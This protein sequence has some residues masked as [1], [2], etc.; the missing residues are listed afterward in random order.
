LEQAIDAAKQSGA[1]GS[2]ADALANLGDVLVERG[3]LALAEQKYTESIALQP[4]KSNKSDTLVALGNL[5]VIEG[6]LDAA[7][8]RFGQSQSAASKTGLASILLAKGSA[9][10]A[11][12]AIRASLTELSKEDPEAGGQARL[13]LVQALLEQ[14]KSVDALKEIVALNALVKAT[15][16]RSL[17]YGALIASARVQA[18]T[19]PQ[20]KVAQPVESLQKVALDA[21][22][23]GMPGF[24]LQARLAIAEIELAD[25]KAAIAHR[26]LE[27]VQHE[28]A[29]KGFGLIQQKAS[30]KAAGR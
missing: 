6:K 16:P 24:E 7:E 19:G 3:T 8:Q 21:K 1:K 13:L 30:A 5:L 27:D 18:A 15:S 22:K 14:G 4:D 29:A 10:Q 17:R 9:A 2:Q 12:T 26:E 23:A 20:A 11:E 25:G 28:A